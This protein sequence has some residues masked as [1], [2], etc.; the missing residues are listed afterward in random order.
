LEGIREHYV[1]FHPEFLN[2]FDQGW[3]ALTPWYQEIWKEK[4]GKVYPTSDINLACRRLDDY[5]WHG[6]EHEVRSL[7]KQLHYVDSP[8][9]KALVSSLMS[10][11]TD[12]DICPPGPSGNVR[13]PDLLQS[14]MAAHAVDAIVDHYMKEFH[15]E[16]RRGLERDGL[17][18]IKDKLREIR[19]G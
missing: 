7:D 2:D 13:E 12:L 11:P 16:L 1:R 17:Q 14:E 15:A 5:T 8:S 10:N 19:Q 4:V 3:D 18:F 9:T 6:W